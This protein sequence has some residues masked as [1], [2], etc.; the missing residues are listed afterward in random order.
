MNI[1]FNFTDNSATA[2]DEVEKKLLVALEACGLQAERYAKM[3]CP[4]DTG[5]LRN[6]ITHVVSGQKIE[7]TY[8]AAY[9]EN[10]G[11]TGKRLSASSKNAGSVGWG[12]YSGTVG[13]EKDFKVIV[14]SNVYYAP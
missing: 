4:V 7:Q 2:L 5:L 10:R 3:K 14:G 8:H 12:A 11:K 13:T 1:S 9:G 6:S